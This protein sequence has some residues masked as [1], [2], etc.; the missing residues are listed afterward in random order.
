MKFL[1]LIASA[2]NLWQLS[3]SVVCSGRVVQRSLR[4]MSLTGA[5]GG[6]EV[7]VPLHNNDNVPAEISSIETL[8]DTPPSLEFQQH[9]M[10]P[11]YVFA[12]V[13]LIESCAT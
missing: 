13:S 4:Q 6:W 8:P 7:I 2:R 9:G 12:C 10:C 3:W 1:P 5:G 11:L